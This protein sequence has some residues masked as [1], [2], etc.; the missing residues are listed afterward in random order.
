MN[1]VTTIRGLFPLHEDKNYTS[2]SEWIILKLLCRPLNG[3]D[4]TN[5]LELSQASGGQISEA[6]CDTLIRIVQISKLS[7]LGTWMARLLA[8]IGLNTNQV[9]HND[10]AIIMDTINKRAGYPICNDVTTR[11]FARLQKEW[12]SNE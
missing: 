9:I 12:I 7:G 10:A 1:T 3:L 11:A 6:R 4:Q 8:D 2:E 5:A